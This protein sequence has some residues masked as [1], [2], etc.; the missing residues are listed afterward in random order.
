MARRPG[1][2][3][4]WVVNIDQVPRHDVSCGGLRGGRSPRLQCI[5]E[6]PDRMPT[7]RPKNLLTRGLAGLSTSTRVSLR[8]EA[9]S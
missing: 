4:V 8:N 9:R 6:R 3:V 5:D 2:A 7:R 1:R